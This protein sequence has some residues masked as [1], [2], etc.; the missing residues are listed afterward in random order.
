M[1]M[2]LMDLPR[3]F[4]NRQVMLLEHDFTHYTT[5]TDGFSSV[6]SDSGTVAVGD[7]AGGKLVVTPSDGSVAD[8]DEAYI[9][10]TNELFLFANNKP[11]V[12]ETI[13]Q[14]TEINTDDA[15]VMFG[16]MN[17]VA[18]NSIVD[19]GAG[20]QASFSGAVIYKVDGGTV[21]K[22]ASSIGTSNTISTTTSTAG[23]SL[24]QRLRIE[25]TCSN[26]VV[27]VNYFIDQLNQ[28]ASATTSIAPQPLIDSTT[29]KPIKHTFSVTSAT[30]MNVF[31]GVKNGGANLETLNLYRL[32]AAQCY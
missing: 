10:S 20:P 12:C 26:S 18:A 17:A 11:Q 19:D 6:I 16:F 15:N 5:A 7:A 4:L 32:C 22:C 3:S 31:A 29:L 8:N 25:C 2:R 24:Y 14:F 9:K 21:W 27:E 30:E 28:L 13:L 1:G 23:G